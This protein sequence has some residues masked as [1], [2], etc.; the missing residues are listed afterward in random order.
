MEA[1]RAIVT[2]VPDNAQ[3]GKAPINQFSYATNL[4]TP[5]SRLIIRPNAD[6]LSTSGWLDLAKEPIVLHVPD[7]AGR[8][9]LIPMLDAYSNEFASVGSRTTGTRERNYAIVGPQWHGSM[10]EKMTGVINAPTNTVWLLGRTLVNGPSDLQNAVAPTRQYQL[11]P[12]SA[13]RKFLETGNYTP[14]AKVAVTP[15]NPDFVGSP[16]TRSRGFS[17]PAFFDV[18]AKYAVENP[19]PANQLAKAS[20][21]VRTGE[22]N[23]NQL[24]STVVSGATTTMINQLSSASKQRN[25]WRFDPNAGNYGADYPLR[26]AIAKFGFGANIPADAVYMT[27][28]TDISGESPTG[29]NS[30]VIHFRTG[31][32]PPERGF[33]SITPYDRSGFLVSNSIDRYDVGSQ[34][35]LVLNPDGSLDIFLQSAAPHAMQGNWLPIPAAPFTLT[36]RIYW[37]DRSVLNGSWTPPSLSK[38]AAPPR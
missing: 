23:R 25:G 1:T 37:P 26:A 14:P 3:P 21:F 4:A 17:M 24:T 5:N 2:A 13:Y 22:I 19:P 8:Y 34:T 36:L 27:A 28:H 35:G 10:P 15:P 16:V 7:V 31:Q 32:T 38:T 6:T 9:Y 33:W 12:L 30:Y 11:I 18:L 20:V 29:I